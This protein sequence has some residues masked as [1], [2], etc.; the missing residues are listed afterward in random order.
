MKKLNVESDDGWLEIGLAAARLCEGNDET[1]AM[2]AKWTKDNP[3]R[4][5]E[6]KANMLSQ[7]FRFLAEDARHRLSQAVRN[8]RPAGVCKKG[9]ETMPKR[10]YKA[11]QMVS[12]ELL[13]SK[14]LDQFEVGGKRLRSVTRT[15]LLADALHQRR[16]ASGNMAKAIF[17]EGLAGRLQ[18]NRKLGNS[19]MGKYSDKQFDDLYDK[20]EAKAKKMLL[21]TG[22]K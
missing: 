2:I 8:I 15:E 16:S 20:A 5:R 6:L 10:D 21:G 1:A 18:G 22:C 3:I 13:K 7:F 19:P 14:W 12:A 9:E 17:E 4:F 11:S